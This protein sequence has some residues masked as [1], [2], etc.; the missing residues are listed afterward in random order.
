MMKMKSNIYIIAIIASILLNSC[1]F[2]DAEKSE[3]YNGFSVLIEYLESKADFV[4]SPETPFFINA[5]EIFQNLD[6]NLLVIDIRNKYDFEDGHIRNSINIKPDEIVN[7]FENK[8]HA[9]GFDRIAIVCNAG[10]KSAF[11]A[12]GMRY[13]GYKNVYPLRNGLSTWN[14]SIA[15]NYRL[16]YISDSHLN[17]LDTVGY[18]KNNPTD[19][20]TIK[21]KHQVP[22]KILRQRVIEILSQD[23]DNYFISFDELIENSDN[24]YIMSY[25]PKARYYSGHLT[26]SVRYQPRQSL[27]SDKHL[28]TLPHDK[29]TVIQCYMGNHASFAAMYLNILGY[30]AKNLIYGAN[31]FIYTTMKNEETSGRFFTREKDVFDFPLIGPEHSKEPEVILPD[32]EINVQGGC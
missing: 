31:N 12:M 4:N 22:Y 10:Y 11:V 2:K 23:L 29:P 16:K 27:R 32:P 15:E 19:F 28:N 14:Y 8:I 25:W 3:E 5:V 9:P 17:K 20:P 18:P 21:T 30:D 13:L 26:G 24:Y 7:L 6:S 1:N